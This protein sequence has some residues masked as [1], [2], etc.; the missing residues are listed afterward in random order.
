MSTQ[1]Y[2][3]IMLTSL[4]YPFRTKKYKTVPHGSQTTT[5]IVKWKITLVFIDMETVS[6]NWIKEIHLSDVS[7]NF[8]PNNEFFHTHIVQLHRY[9]EVGSS[10]VKL[11]SWETMVNYTRI[12]LF[13]Y[14]F[15][16]QLARKSRDL[17]DYNQLVCIC[18]K[19]LTYIGSI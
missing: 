3:K 7:Y 17:T 1:Y 14:L 19:I 16:F 15:V 2:G 8:I 5:G 9:K 12:S 10:V 13:V 11:L 18:T 4:S 6:S